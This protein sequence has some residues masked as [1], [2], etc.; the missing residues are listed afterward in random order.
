MVVDTSALAAILLDEPEASDFARRITVA[1]RPVI[2]AAGYV[3]F[4]L[5]A[6]SR[7]GYGWPEIDDALSRFGLEVV[8][9]SPAQAR[10]AVEAFAR[11]GKGRHPAGLNFGDCFAY[12]LAKELGRPLLFKGGDFALTDVEPAV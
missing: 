10:R 1:S 8:P 12:A 3:G 5:L 2:S 11:F 9:V 6:V 4:G 7:R